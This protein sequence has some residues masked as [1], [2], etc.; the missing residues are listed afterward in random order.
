MRGDFFLGGKTDHFPAG[1]PDRRVGAVFS[2][3]VAV[4]LNMKIKTLGYA[5]KSLVE[6]DSSW[7]V[8]PTAMTA[9]HG[10]CNNS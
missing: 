10:G 8:N 6:F 4:D 5:G 7:P 2:S 9:G 1:D 3:Q